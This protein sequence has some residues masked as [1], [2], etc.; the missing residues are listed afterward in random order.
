MGLEPEMVAGRR[1]TS[2]EVLEVAKMVFNGKLNTDLLAA[3]RKYAVYG[4]GL[5]GIDGGLIRA[6]KRPV[7]RMKDKESNETRDI[8]FGFVGDVAEVN[9]SVI[10]HLIGGEFIPGGD[11]MQ[12]GA[13]ARYLLNLG[14]T[15]WMYLV[16][17]LP[18]VAKLFESQATTA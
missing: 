4:V 18:D 11:S 7:T 2:P 9:P 10:H 5:S 15:L 13:A 3:L 17:T 1:V 12:L 6:S 14:V 8:D 16:L